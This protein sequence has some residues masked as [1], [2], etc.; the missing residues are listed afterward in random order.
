MYA[1]KVH[2]VKDEKETDEPDEGM[3]GDCDDKSSNFSIVDE[4]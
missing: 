1:D 3:N 4:D 2:P